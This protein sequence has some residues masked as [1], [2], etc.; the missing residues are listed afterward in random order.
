MGRWF[1]H[2][3]QKVDRESSNRGSDGPRQRCAGD[4]QQGRDR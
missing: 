3:D 2:G 1:L 4:E